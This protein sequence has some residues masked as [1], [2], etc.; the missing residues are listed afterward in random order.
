[1]G[2]WTKKSLDSLLF[3]KEESHKLKQKLGP[4]QL[5]LLGIGAIIGAGLF[6]ITGIAAAENAGP[7]IT[8]SFL[9]AAAGCAFAGL[10]Y[11]ELSTMLPVA[12]SAYT[13]AYA[14][15][16]ELVAWIIGWDLVLEYAMGASAV[17]ISWSAYI[18]SFLH[19]YNITLPTDLIASP[20]Q[21]VRLPDG[22][23]VYGLINIPAVIIVC[24]IS[25]L[26]MIG[27]KESAFVNA[28]IVLI[29]VSIV[30]VFIAVGIFYIKPSNYV[31]FIPNN[32]GVFGEYGLSGILRAAGVVFFAYIGFDAVSTAAQETKNPQKAMP[33]GIIGS[34]IICTILYILFSFV[35]T[36]LVNYKDLKVA[37]PVALAIDQTPFLWLNSLIK[38]AIL[39]GFTSVIL[40]LLLGQS[41]IFYSMSKD[42]L[43]PPIFS[44]IH[45][46]FHTPWRC[47][48]ILLFF[49]S[50][51]GAFLPLS[52]VG[53]MTSIGTLLAFVIVS[54]GVLLLRYRHPEIPRSFRTPWVPFVPIMGIII[55]LT[56]MISLGWENWIRLLVWLLIGL[57][58]YFFY[59]RRLSLK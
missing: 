19:D 32:T 44:D 4:F 18:V 59:S 7:A 9:I 10:C 16:G 17:S 47:N 15:M 40:V 50:T 55:C 11:S 57:L 51:I 25:G 49:V 27:I 13:Y 58:V 38:L 20:W 52:V 6:S 31:P 26:L 37:A 41:R 21:P 12:G 28:I 54:I 46:R 5:I 42:G 24:G 48:L 34:L 2:I 43:L 33:I 35:M 30:I 3:N 14:T 8:L 36:G 39:A 45:P 23:L 22:T 1:M 56:M 53:H 29:K